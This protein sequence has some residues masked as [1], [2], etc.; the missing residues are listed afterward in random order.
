M[1]DWIAPSV[2]YDLT[3]YDQK[4]SWDVSVHFQSIKRYAHV[5]DIVKKKLKQRAVEGILG[6][7]RDLVGQVSRPERIVSLNQKEFEER[8][9]RGEI[10]FDSTLESGELYF[11]AKEPIERKIALLM[12]CSMSMKGEKIAL[13]GVAVVAVAMAVSP[14]SL[15]L[16]GFDSK[17]K[18]IKHF[19]EDLTL[20]E[21]AER[22]LDLPAGGFTN[23]ELGFEEMLRELDQVR[24]PDARVILV[25]DGKYTEGRDPL[26]LADRFRHLHVLKLGADQ[27]GRE[28]LKVIAE[29]GSGRFFEA[30]KFL[31]LPKTLYET[32]R[33][34]SR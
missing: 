11:E 17:A 25:G 6:R 15:C 8:A 32:V 23:M 28:L 22:I 14:R 13:L 31:D 4:T 9:L 20:S 21:I 29:R 10:D 16:L 33:T 26:F 12:D 30:R 34:V 1:D 27:G 2:V 19:S 18:W 7:A 5:T 3:G 24:A